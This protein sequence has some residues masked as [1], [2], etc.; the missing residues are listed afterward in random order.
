[1]R[2][3]VIGSG[4]G[5]ASCAY[6][7]A[8]SGAEVVVVD[9]AT[10]GAATAAGAGIVSPWTSRRAGEA[11]LELAT[12]AAAYHR[13]LADE[14]AADGE[15]GSSFE[16][17]GA[18]VVSSDDTDL[19][20]L[21]ERLAAR[22]AR[23]PEMGEVRRL[24]E[25]AARERFPAL[26]RDLGAVHVSGGGRV[27]GDAIRSALLRSAARHGARA[28]VGTARPVWS[29]DR[30][31]GVTVG[32][33]RIAGDAVVVAAGAWTPHVLAP[34]GVPVPVEP[35]R[36]QISHFALPGTDTTAWPVV[37]PP[38]GHYLLAFPGSHVVAGATRETGSGFDHRVTAQG[39]REVLDHAL[40]V[41]P[42]LAGATLTETRV[43]FRPATPDGL[44]IIGALDGCP[45][46]VLATGFGPGGLTVAP[47]AGR[48]AAQVALGEAPDTPL[49]AVNPARFRGA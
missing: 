33:E 39:Q 2:V 17:V 26:A 29:G 30:L 14:L 25:A 41:A 9:A 32:A 44:P 6:H 31:G 27:D 16:V 19:A 1:M 49:D 20:A 3:I 38:T 5:G 37:L 21:G 47:Y 35:Q 24:D 45:G 18:L 46:V 8:R 42:G 4:I 28:V 13:R 23:W 43:G 15:V 7:L 10:E 34:L 48:L 22:A 12:T 11:E 36:G 40:R